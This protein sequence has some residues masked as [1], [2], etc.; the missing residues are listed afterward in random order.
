METKIIDLCTCGPVHTNIS[1]F[2]NSDKLSQRDVGRIR[3]KAEEP[4]IIA[5]DGGQSDVDRG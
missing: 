1:M 2:M 5:I 3:Y 4:N